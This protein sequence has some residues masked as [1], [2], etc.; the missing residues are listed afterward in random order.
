MMVETLLVVS[1]GRGLLK[2]ELIDG[3]VFCVIFLF[4]GAIFVDEERAVLEPGF[5]TDIRSIVR[6]VWD[7]KLV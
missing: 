3:V 4:V 5:R 6:I 2:K 7:F 1:Q